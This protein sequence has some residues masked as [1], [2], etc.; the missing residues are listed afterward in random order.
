M[1]RYL[2]TACG[3]VIVGTYVV[4]Q[5]GGDQTSAPTEARLRETVA[6]LRAGRIAT[7]ARRCHG[8]CARTSWGDGG[9]GHCGH[10]D[11]EHDAAGHDGGV[12]R[13]LWHGEGRRVAE[14]AGRGPPHAWYAGPRHHRGRTSRRGVRGIR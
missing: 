3:L 12:A 1:R 7:P 14:N 9:C 5:G 2:I 4:A 6:N 11:D 8:P 10:D 13:D